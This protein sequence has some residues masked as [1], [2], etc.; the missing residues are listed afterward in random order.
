MVNIALFK[1]TKRFRILSGCIQIAHRKG[2]LGHCTWNAWPPSGKGLIC[3]N[4][5]SIIINTS[6][7]GFGALVYEASMI[8]V[9]MLWM[10]KLKHRGLLV[11]TCR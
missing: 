6:T 11:C 8:M 2:Y 3:D 9:H 7:E 1:K 10:R 4:V 5:N